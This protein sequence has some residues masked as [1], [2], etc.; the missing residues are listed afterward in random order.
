MKC[1]ETEGAGR[2]LGRHIR[3]IITSDGVTGLYVA[4]GPQQREGEGRN[5]F[6]EEKVED[7]GRRRGACDVC[8]V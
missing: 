1:L 4:H 8:D 6:E 2:I 3:E 5:A 7:E